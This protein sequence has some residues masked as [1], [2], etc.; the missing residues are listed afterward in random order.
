MDSD[1]MALPLRWRGG[2]ARIMKLY[3]LPKRSRTEFSEAPETRMGIQAV[4]LE[5]S[6]GIVIASQIL[7]V[8]RD[9]FFQPGRAQGTDRDRDPFGDFFYYHRAARVRESLVS[10]RSLET[11][12]EDWLASLPEAPEGSLP[13]NPV[14]SASSAAQILAYFTLGPI[15]ALHSPP[16]R[17][18]Y[19]YG[20]L[21]FQGVC[22]EG[23]V[24]YRFES[25]PT[26]WRIDQKAG[27]VA[28]GTFGCPPSELP[29]IP[30]GLAAVAR[31]ALPSVLPARWRYEIRPEPGTRFF[32]GASVPLYGQ[33]GGGVEVMFP[34]AF[35]N[36]GPI[37]NPVVM[38]E[39]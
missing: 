5:G 20:H 17:P 30:T 26:G 25:S 12:F 16:A 1:P 38:P 37:A 22:T 6:P 24:F 3:R 7:A 19:V 15:A 33:S 34:D 11:Q 2:D 21:P 23:D 39:L 36:V 29:L 27:M 18:P 8:L 35:Q 28:G 31:Y 13:V 4:W 32:Y 14:T 9:E 10:G